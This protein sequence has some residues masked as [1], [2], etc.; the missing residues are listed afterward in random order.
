[1]DTVEW[2]ERR[3]RM[4]E[5]TPEQWC[6]NLKVLEFDIGAH[7]FDSLKEFITTPYGKGGLGIPIEKA[8]QF[9][10]YNPAY[11][12]Q[13]GVF[14]QK[15]GIQDQAINTPV[16]GDVGVSKPSKSE[17]RNIKGGSNQRY[18]IAKL[19]RDYPEIAFR[20]EQGEFTT[21]SAAERAAGI[22]GP[23]MSTVEKLVRAYDRLSDSEKQ[24]YRD[25][26]CPRCNS[27]DTVPV[28]DTAVYRGGKYKNQYPTPHTGEVK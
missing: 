16:L 15:L 6:P 19:K 25:I 24:E 7:G 4:I 17:N 22:L 27:W 12:H 18:R 1:M 2:D 8:I 10:E 11:E 21:V 9:L 13:A 3:L 14:K 20:M 23:K 28:Q 5:E 26:V